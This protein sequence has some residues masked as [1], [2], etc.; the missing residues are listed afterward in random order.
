MKKYI[1][2]LLLSV[3]F[4]TN[5]FTVASSRSNTYSIYNPKKIK[6][7]SYKGLFIVKPKSEYAEQYVSWWTRENAIPF[8]PTEGMRVE[9]YKRYFDYLE[10]NQDDTLINAERYIWFVTSEKTGEIV[11]AIGA[12]TVDPH[13]KFAY[14]AYAVG[15]GHEHKGIGSKSLFLLLK[16]LFDH[17][18]F[19]KISATVAVGNEYSEKILKKFNFK[20]E[21]YLRKQL[22]SQGVKKDMKLFSLLKSEWEEFKSSLK[23]EV[24]KK[25]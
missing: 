19:E 22:L 5:A 15:T 4:S 17:M 12:H 11:A 18:G 16:K 9:V 6:K 8:N 7:D 14:I 13:N 25:K 1:L 24:N 21:G 20:Q 10:K 23:S 3:Y 2:F